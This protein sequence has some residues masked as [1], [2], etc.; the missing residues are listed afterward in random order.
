MKIEIEI[1]SE[2]VTHQRR[3]QITVVIA[4]HAN[5]LSLFEHLVDFLG[6]TI[7]YDVRLGRVFDLFEQGSVGESDSVSDV[8]GRLIAA[9]ASARSDSGRGIN[10]G[11]FASVNVFVEHHDQIPAARHGKRENESGQVWYD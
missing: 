5:L 10:V 8:D 7:Q 11:W 3:D 4:H 9:A 2:L 1:L 6:G